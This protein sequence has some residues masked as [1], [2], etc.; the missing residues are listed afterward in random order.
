MK[1]AIT[2]A[3]GLIGSAMTS[4]LEE[5]GDEV[6]RL[7]RRPARNASEVTWDPQKGVIDTTALVGCDAVVHL[8]GANISD[9]RWTEDRKAL[10]LNSR[11]DGTRL[12]ASTI[13]AM[14]P[15]PT[16][17]ISSSA[18]GIYGSRGDELL[19]EEARPGSGFLAEVCLAWEAETAPARAAGVRTVNMRTGIV[20]SA[21]D[22]AL[23][24]MLPLFKAGVGGKLGDG[25]QYMSW[26]TLDDMID[27]V[28]FALDHDNLEG[29]VNFCA[30]EPVTNQ[31]FT[32]ALGAALKRPT[33]L[34][35]PGFALKVAFGEMAEN[36][37]L[38]GQRVAPRKLL[39]AGYE[40][41]HDAIEEALMELVR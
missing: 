22:G 10:I 19:D 29:P 36:V 5:R 24:K 14:K 28:I 33:F 16:V 25:K 13:A 20:L 41:R 34:P 23:A 21:E 1:I 26:I 38:G 18:V 39:E 11:V 3:S 8:A 9:G 17:F 12:I 6:L 7:V 40:F 4:A 27:A 35:A 2:G 32:K 37:L 31:R 30:P 15:A